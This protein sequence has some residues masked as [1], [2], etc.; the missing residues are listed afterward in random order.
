ML[1][2]LNRQEMNKAIK[3]RNWQDFRQ[4]LKGTSTKTKLERLRLYLSHSEA[5]CGRE[6]K[7]AQVLNYL[8]ALA[9]GGQ[10]APLPKTFSFNFVTNIDWTL[11]VTVQR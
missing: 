6:E 8:H 1:P 11:Q 5:C 10:I 2:T 4:S 7:T 3:C 9:R